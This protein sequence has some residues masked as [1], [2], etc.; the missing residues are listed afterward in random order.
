[1]PRRK[2]IPTPAQSR[3]PSLGDVLLIPLD[4]SK[5]GACRVLWVEFDSG[6]WRDAVLGLCDWIG[7]TIPV[8]LEPALRPL[9]T[10]MD[11]PPWGSELVFKPTRPPPRQILRIGT[12]LPS[13]LERELGR[14]K[15]VPS[16]WSVVPEAITAW[17]QEAHSSDLKLGR[18]DAKSHKVELTSDEDPKNIPDLQSFKTLKLF[19]SWDGQYKPRF[20]QAARKLIRETAAK[21]KKSVS[22][23]SNPEI[24]KELRHL[25]QGFNRLD[26]RHGNPIDT[27]A[28]E[29]ILL[30]FR[31]M[32]WLAGVKGTQTIEDHRAW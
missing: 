17:W 13:F 15:L 4:Q 7:T 20:V 24:R 29:D 30:I 11:S 12:V 1:M 25:L 14:A 28:A 8:P 32:A 21:L 2:V 26:D 18:L 10:R 27:A 19:S 23:A 16:P 3:A 9:L 22:T 6:D 31:R 5:F